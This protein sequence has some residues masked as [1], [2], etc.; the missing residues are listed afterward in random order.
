[1]VF[2]DIPKAFDRVWHKGLVFKLKQHGI[3]GLLL[4]W[5]TDYLNNRSQKVVIRSCVS[6]AMYTN[7]GVPQGSVLGPLLFLVYVVVALLFY[8]HGKHLRSCRNGQLT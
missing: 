2:C 1:M 7:A 6:S 4:D 5:I 8:V 3:S